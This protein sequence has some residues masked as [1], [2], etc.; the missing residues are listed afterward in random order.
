MKTATS[1]LFAKSPSINLSAKLS[2][3]DLLNCWVVIYLSWSDF[4]L[5]ISQIFV[6]SQI[7][8][9]NYSTTTNPFR[10]T[11]EITHYGETSIP[12]I[13]CLVLRQ[14]VRQ[15]VYIVFSTN[16][17]ASFLVVKRKFGKTSKSLKILWP[18]WSLKYSS[19]FQVFINSSSYY[20]K[21]CFG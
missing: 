13:L 17:R 5:S 8:Q 1:F 10:E 3:V 15:F 14:L 7:F 16:N 4:F 6:F 21:S 2:D 11:R 12:N 18:W 9:L 19:A 20:K